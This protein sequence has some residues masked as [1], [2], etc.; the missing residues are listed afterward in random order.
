M[1]YSFYLISKDK[2]ISEQDYEIAIKKLLDFNRPGVYG[3]PTC[4]TTYSPKYISVSG[5]Y[6]Y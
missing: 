3:M 2:P 6:S 4:D 5:S 1:G